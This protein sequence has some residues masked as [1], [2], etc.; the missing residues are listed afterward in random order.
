MKGKFIVIEGLDGTGKSSVI[1]EIKNLLN[2][3]DTIVF[4][5]EP[6]GLNNS[7]AENIRNLILEESNEIDPLTE[8]YL[9]SASRAKHTNEIKRLL[10]EGKTII[11][12]RYVYSSLYYQGIMKELGTQ[13]V[14][15]INKIALNNIKPDMILYFIASDE[16]RKSRMMKRNNL[17]RIDKEIMKISSFDATIKYLNVIHS[18]KQKST[19][20]EIIDTSSTTP[21]EAAQ[22]MLQILTD[23]KYI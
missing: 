13:T 19:K 4:T 3:D 14:F 21:D 18:Y 8:A 23:N 22:K 2:D 11:C 12:D 7:I 20:V 10:D 6:G 16:V 5:R 17:N 9:F 1:N 15:N